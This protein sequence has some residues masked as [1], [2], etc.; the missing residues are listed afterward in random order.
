M[1]TRDM[2]RAQFAAACRR[3]GFEPEA[4]GYYHLPIPGHHVAVNVL[5]AGARR[6][7]RLAYLHAET[8]RLQKKYAAEEARP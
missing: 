3:A 6:R 4:F 2:T 7:D 5:N 8:A 1:T